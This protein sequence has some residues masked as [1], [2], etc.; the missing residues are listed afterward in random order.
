MC[1]IKTFNIEKKVVFFFLFPGGL[2][3]RDF[4][5]IPTLQE[6]ECSA[7][8]ISRPVH[9]CS[10][11][12]FELSNDEL[13]VKLRSSENTCKT[14]AEFASCTLITSGDRRGSAVRTLVSD[15]S[16]GRTV[17]IGCNGTCVLTHN[18]KPLEFSWSINAKMKSKLQ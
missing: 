3:V 11:K 7:H 2:N 16:R 12:L 15:W 9:M 14:Y 17:A 1:P 6:V 8:A 18:D 4:K 10:L 13:L 5:G